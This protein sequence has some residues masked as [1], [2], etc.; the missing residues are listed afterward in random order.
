MSLSTT[1]R[2]LSLYLE[3]TENR[4]A[5]ISPGLINLNR[6]YLNGQGLDY[7]IKYLERYCIKPAAKQYTLEHASITQS[8]DDIFPKCC[9]LEVAE[10]IA[11][12]LIQTF[13]NI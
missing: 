8:V 7:F 11:R 9:R 5:Y 4:L 10:D 1:A 2:E 13:K 6:A 3:Q 12:K